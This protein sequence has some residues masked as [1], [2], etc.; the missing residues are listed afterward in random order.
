MKH[1]IILFAFLLI[2]PNAAKTNDYD[3]KVLAEIDDEE[4][5]YERL[6]YAF[7]KNMVGDK[8]ELIELEKDSLL[9]FLDLFVKYRLKV[10]DAIDRGFH[11]DPE[12]VDEITTNKNLLTE[13]YYYDKKVFQPSVNRLLNRRQ[14]YLKFGYILFPFTEE[15]EGKT[16]VDPKDYAQSVLDSINTGKITFTQAAQNHS[17]EKDLRENGGVVNKYLISGTIQKPIEDVLFELNSGQI[18]GTLLK[19]DYG[20]FIIKLVD[21]LQ[22]VQLKAAHI[23]I[24]KENTNEMLTDKQHSLADSLLKLIRN[25]ESFEKLAELHS[26]DHASAVNGGELHDYYDLSTG[27]VKNK[28]ILDDYFVNTLMRLKDGEVSDTIHTIYG[29]HIVKRVDTKKPT[30]EKDR[31][32]I[33]SMYKRTRYDDAKKSFYENYVRTNGFELN[34]ESLTSILSNVD[35]TK[36]NLDS[37][38]ASK[39]P[40]DINDD[41]LFEFG[42]EVWTVSKFANV[43]SDK[44]KTEYRATPLSRKGLQSA[45]FKLVKP[46]ILQMWSKELMEDDKKYQNLVN[47]FK[48]GILLFKVEAIEVWDNLELDTAMAKAYFDTTSKEF[49]TEKKYDLS[50]IFI[51]Q[52]T[53]SKELYKRIQDGEDFREL[54]ANYTV[55]QGYREKKG[56]HG[57]V[58]AEQNKFS[59]QLKGEEIKDGTII[60]PKDY[61]SGISIIKINKVIEPRVKTFEEALIDLAPIVQSLKQKSLVD[62]WLNKVRKKHKVEINNDVI[63]EIYED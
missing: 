49:Y 43:L 47:E 23:L 3:D 15:A 52:D 6:E 61:M 2:L 4:V 30:I 17:P 29:I 26:D 1:F 33:E 36:T 5:T 62:N 60:P 51:L 28:G 40:N 27:F 21:K 19:T 9:S 57:M 45:M 10:K 50:E 58:S 44:S 46:Q 54:A 8:K 24:G 13:S 39:I 37:N 63:D 14:Y 56:Y 7:Q 11:K 34:S 12:L 25:G 59:R 18:N 38:W 48:D 42:D 20:Y 32:E 31:K 22:R 41:V 55:R 35:Y 53:L 16:Q